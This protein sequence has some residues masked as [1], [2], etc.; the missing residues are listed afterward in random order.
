[1]RLF[2]IGE[3]VDNMAVGCVSRCSEIVA[4]SNLHF[5]FLFLG[6]RTF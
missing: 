6:V 1:M 4:K 2:N 5:S 3:S